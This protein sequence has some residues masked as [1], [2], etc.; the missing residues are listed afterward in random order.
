MFCFVS[1]A[2]TRLR[3]PAAVSIV[4]ETVLS[5]RSCGEEED[6][7]LSQRLRSSSF[8]LVLTW[9]SRQTHCL[10]RYGLVQT[11]SPETRDSYRTCIQIRYGQ[12]HR[13]SSLQFKT[14][15]TIA[16][17][18]RTPRAYSAKTLKQPGKGARYFHGRLSRRERR[19]Q[20][21]WEPRLCFPW[22]DS[23]QRSSVTP[24]AK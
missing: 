19:D 21:Q 5:S 22:P 14:D 23:A 16:P 17:L 6:G 3:E 12:V 20:R 2:V 9:C 4:R 7:R 15:E 24:Q 13:S 1:E 18:E 11:G 8:W 10:R